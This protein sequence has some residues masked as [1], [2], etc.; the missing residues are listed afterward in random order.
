MK[1]KHLYVKP[2]TN[3]HKS[4]ILVFTGRRLKPGCLN[5]AAC[6]A[7]RRAND[8][9]QK[10]TFKCFTFFPTYFYK[11]ILVWYHCTHHLVL[12]FLAPIYE[13]ANP[14]EVILYLEGFLASTGSQLRPFHNDV[15]I[16]FIMWFTEYGHLFT[17]QC[18][19]YQLPRYMYPLNLG[20]LEFNGKIWEYSLFRPVCW[21]NS[22]GPK[23]YQHP[24]TVTYLSSSRAHR[25]EMWYALLSTHTFYVLPVWNTR[26]LPSPQHHSL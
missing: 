10:E 7:D 9:Q 18:E 2:M 15:S 14:S 5:E 8:Q 16:L 25:T 24:F 1:D 23:L 19:S 6:M 3:K 20:I 22:S 4:F 11:Y 21:G 26:P 13:V 12:K 17:Q